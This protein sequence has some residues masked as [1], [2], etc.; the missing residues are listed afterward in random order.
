MENRVDVET[1]M[2]AVERVQYYAA[3]ETEDY[4]G[5]NHL[6]RERRL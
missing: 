4:G 2:N 5:K 6:P 3:V 1:Q